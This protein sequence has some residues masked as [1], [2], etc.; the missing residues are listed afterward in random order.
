MQI[1]RITVWIPH[2]FLCS[3]RQRQNTSRLIHCGVSL[4]M[5][6]PQNIGTTEKKSCSRFEPIDF[7]FCFI[8]C[9]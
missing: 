4:E 1:Q 6:T 8:P 9:F 5:I 3:T 7:L 2:R